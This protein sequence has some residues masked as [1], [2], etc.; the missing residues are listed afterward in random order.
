[1]TDDTR[2]EGLTETSIRQKFWTNISVDNL[3][4]TYINDFNLDLLNIVVAADE[5]YNLEFLE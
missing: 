4:N 2:E 5:H 3:D 1:M